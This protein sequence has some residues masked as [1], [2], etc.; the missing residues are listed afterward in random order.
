MER[1]GDVEEAE[2]T[3]E[4][5]EMGVITELKREVGLIVEDS[6]YDG[7]SEEEVVAENERPIQL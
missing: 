3:E 4:D 6:E 5:V 1:V 7:D 2:K